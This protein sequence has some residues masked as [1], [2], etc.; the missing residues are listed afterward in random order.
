MSPDIPERHGLYPPR[1]RRRELLRGETFGG[2]IAKRGTVLGSLAAPRLVL[3][4]GDKGK[5][6]DFLE[7]LD[8]LR[9]EGY[10]VTIER[11]PAFDGYTVEALPPGLRP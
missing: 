10:V 1:A 9:A 11:S 2:H 3:V 8:G 4:K 6:D 7:W 5:A